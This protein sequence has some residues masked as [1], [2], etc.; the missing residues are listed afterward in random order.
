MFETTKFD[1]NNEILLC[2]QKDKH[3]NMLMTIYV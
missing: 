3:T 1:K 2:N